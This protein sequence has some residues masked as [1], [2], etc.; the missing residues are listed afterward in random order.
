MRFFRT[1]PPVNVEH[2]ATPP[3]TPPQAMSRPPLTEG[4]SENE[5]I[6]VYHAAPVKL[7]KRGEL[8]FNDLVNT[9][10]FFV[11]IDGEIQVTVKLN[12][13][14]GRPGFFKKGDCVAPLPLSAGL[15]YCAE[16][17]EDSTIIEIS[18]TVLKHLPDKTQLCIYKVAT[19]STSKINAYIRAVNGEINLRNLRLSQYI[20]H[21]SAARSAVIQTEFVKGFVQNM[22]RMPTYATDLAVQ[23]LDD[24][25][26][27]REVV[28]GIKADPSLVGIVLRT[29][30]SA[31]YGFAKKIESFYHACMIL[32][33]NNIYSLLMRE[34]AQSTMPITRETTRIHKH[35]CLISVLSFEIASVAKEQ[36]AQMVATVGLL[37]DFG[38]GVQVVMKNAHRDRADF[39][40][41]LDSAKL[42]AAL[43]RSWG[44]PERI[45][46]TVEFQQHP[47]FM[48]PDLVAP[49][50]RKEVAALHIAHVLETLLLDRPV[51]PIR[52]IY[53]SEYMTLLGFPTVTPLTLLKERILP[54]LTKD[55][56]RVP[57][58]IHTIV[59]NSPLMNSRP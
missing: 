29:V 9:D 28:E 24:N 36:Q 41:S 52:S 11:L 44:L 56:S 42:G 30:N 23:L 8:I 3:A 55:R 5:L 37:H 31:Q 59:F 51:D 10:S 39:V 4:W 6:S 20:L 1:L 46:R 22:R 35:S 53:A 21:Q 14:H 19:N 17:V 26:S 27:V 57:P 18:P 32:G 2:P 58:D 40:E 16:A 48:S 13:Q 15:L 12:G 45:C 25:T 7:F 33:F 49:E 43:L 34:A 38:K 47:E 50:Y 54:T